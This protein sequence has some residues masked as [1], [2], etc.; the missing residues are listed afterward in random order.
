MVLQLVNLF[1]SSPFP[2]HPSETA[3]KNVPLYSSVRFY[4]VADI[5]PVL[6]IIRARPQIQNLKIRLRHESAWIIHAIR[7]MIGHS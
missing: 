4:F 3:I 2:E 5:R 7:V 1:L 6:R